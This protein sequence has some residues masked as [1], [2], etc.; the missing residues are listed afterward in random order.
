MQYQRGRKSRKGFLFTPG[1]IL[2]MVVGFLVI[3][4]LIFLIGVM[5]GR[6]ML[7][8]GEIKLGFLQRKEET[9]GPILEIEEEATP[10]LIEPSM[11]EEIPSPTRITPT[12][13]IPTKITP[14]PRPSPVST[15]AVVKSP[16]PRETITQDNYYLQIIAYSRAE[17]AKRLEEKLKS[18]EY[19]ARVV[20]AE[21]PEGTRYRVIVEGYSTFADAVRAGDKIVAQLGLQERP[22]VLRRK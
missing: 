5:V 21:L 16:P 17:S 13:I 12:K 18:L 22:M 19:S 10:A 3:A 6:G 4:G 11:P 9:P 1:Q 15:P 7:G 20:V 2:V 8:K 14:T